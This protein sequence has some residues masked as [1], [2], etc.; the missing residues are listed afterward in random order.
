MQTLL[1]LYSSA[2]VFDAAVMIKNARSPADDLCHEP[3][4]WFGVFVN[5]SMGVAGPAHTGRRSD[6][7]SQ[8]LP[9]SIT[10]KKQTATSVFLRNQKIF[11]NFL[12]D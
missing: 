1:R 5:A 3:I 4:Y 2:A 11:H 10:E 12:M 7:P 8:A 6:A 9:N